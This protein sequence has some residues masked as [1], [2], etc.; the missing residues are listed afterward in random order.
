MLSEPLHPGACLV[1]RAVIC[2]GPQAKDV[3]EWAY[4]NQEALTAA[5]K[6]GPKQ[7]RAAIQ[8]RWGAKSLQCMDARSTTQTLERHLHFAADNSIPMSTPQMY[9]GAQRF[10]DEDTDIGLRFTMAQVS[11]EVVR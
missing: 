3:L 5:G 6:A 11:P 4:D 1:S 10:C 2:G 9:L 8:A 7:L